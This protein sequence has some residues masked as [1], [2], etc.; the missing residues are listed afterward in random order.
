ML[1]R[2][3][4]I[5]IFSLPSVLS[6]QKQDTIKPVLKRQWTLSSDYSEEVTVPVDTAFSLFHRLKLVDKYSPFN[7][8]SGNYGL[9]LYQINFFDRV[10]NP[11]M[12][13]YSNYYPFMH[14]PDNPVFMNTQIPFSEMVF[15]YAGPTDR[16]DQT[17]RIR[18]SQNV[19]RLLNFGLIYDIVFSLGQYS[20]QR[21]DDKTFTLYSSYSGEKYKLYFAAGINNITSVE[22]GGIRDPSQMSTAD[23]RFLEV[24]LGGLNKAKSILKNRNVLIVQKY[25]V[26]KKP[27][28]VPDS[29]NGKQAQRKFR[30][31][32]T[33]SHIFAW[34][35]N[36]RTYI[37]YYPKSGFY[38][39]AYINR[40]FTLDSL[41]SGS[42]KNTVRFDFS[43]DET[44]KFRLGGGVGL[45]N[46]LFRYGQIVPNGI[47]PV[48]DTVFYS[49]T[50]KW[51]YSNNVLIGRLFNNI[52]EKFRWVASGELFL[53]GYRAGD[54]TLDGRFIKSFDFKKGRADWEIFGKVTN[55]QPSV[56]YERWGS[57]NFK[58]QNNFLK[59]FRIT[60]GTQFNYPARRATL[61]F[62]Y[63]IID[64]YTDFGP[65]TL[66]SQFRGGLS[67][68][69]IYLKKEFSAWKFHLSNDI[70]I[71]KS[72]NNTVLDL[73]L[74]TVRSAGFFEHNFHFKLTNGNLNTQFG[75]EVMYNTPYHGYSYMPSIGRFFRQS[76]SLTGDYPYVNV[77][78]NVK[79]KRTRFF[80]MFDHVN[81]GLTGYNYFMVPSNP[82]NIRMFKYGLAWTFYD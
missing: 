68:A 59:E 15:S 62:N 80:L 67:V 30:V 71:Q 75:A 27:A 42:L 9:P 37:D 46:E 40:T 32:G 2:I 23:T 66:P 25:T 35:I 53:S 11:D 61:R 7:A 82:M 41:S 43:T 65:D 8:Y 33:F 70:L 22:N 45:R 1:K 48:S 31:D 34:E 17:F 28:V 44:R 18:H 10:T 81:S 26:N 56:W 47:S 24:N 39:T 79:L 64:N 29:V 5:L 36:R 58:W 55:L 60:A 78:I 19:N 77:F 51:K 49:D 72:T 74:I 16:S 14:L 69:A 13:L 21:S 52:G 54:F 6:A 3:S 12:F 73:P 57:N 20:Y 76:L 4:F 50:V 63:A 38:D